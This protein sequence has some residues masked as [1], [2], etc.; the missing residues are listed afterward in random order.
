MNAAMGQSKSQLRGL[1][2]ALI[3]VGA[4]AACNDGMVTVTYSTENKG[5]KMPEPKLGSREQCYGISL[6]QYNDG[7]AGCDDCAGT[8]LKDYLPDTWKYVPMG[9]CVR[10]GGSLIAGKTPK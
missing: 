3:L 4:L 10:M 1:A 8:A 5:I 6:A 9:Q 7:T 2:G